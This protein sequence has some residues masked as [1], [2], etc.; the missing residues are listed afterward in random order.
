MTARPD[1]H[2]L[3]LGPEVP[4]SA[5]FTA[6]AI[7][8]TMYGT[9]GQLHDWAETAAHHLVDEVL[10]DLGIMDALDYPDVADIMGNDPRHAANVFRY[11]V[12]WRHGGLW[13]DHDVLPLVD[14][15]SDPRAGAWTAGFRATHQR[16]GCALWF[17]EPEHPMLATLLERATAPSP[18]KPAPM[19]SGAH[20]LTEVGR[21][22][23]VGVNH[24]V[25]PYDSTG[26]LTFRGRPD[27]VH[28][29]EGSRP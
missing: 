12:L 1:V 22:S 7:R 28:L 20:L 24:R 16:E 9:S 10:V 27:A 18:P 4:P 3:W 25:L 19:R 26:R 15:R 21:G 5:T 11:A 6:N 2:R 13:L 8:S 17:P 14:L 29:W 23:G